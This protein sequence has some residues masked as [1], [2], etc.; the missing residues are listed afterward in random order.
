MIVQTVSYLLISSKC[1]KRLLCL[2]PGPWSYSAPDKLEGLWNKRQGRAEEIGRQWWFG[3]LSRF[4]GVIAGENL[5]II[6]VASESLFPTNYDFNGTHQLFSTSVA[7]LFSG[8][9]VQYVWL[10][11]NL[12]FLVDK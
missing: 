11:S 6:K 4:L 3:K 10:D 9:S 2:F 5:K 8:L 12:F 7:V 1:R